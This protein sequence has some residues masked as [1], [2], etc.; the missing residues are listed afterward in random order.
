MKLIPEEISYLRKEARR[1]KERQDAYYEYMKTREIKTSQGP[2]LQ[3][4]GDTFT[5]DTFQREIQNYHS[6][7]DTL[8]NAEY[9]THPSTEKIEV[10]TKFVVS[11]ES[12]ED[13]DLLVLTESGF[14]FLPNDMF[15]TIDSPL[16]QEIQ[17]KKAGES[18]EFSLKDDIRM[19]L[20]RRS[21]KGEIKE[22]KTDRKLYVQFIRN[23][24]KSHRISKAIPTTNEE[25]LNTDDQRKLEITESQK[26]LLEIELKRLTKKTR[27]AGESCRLTNIKKILRN[28]TIATPRTDDKIGIGSTFE[29]V[30]TNG[31]ET[32]TKECEMIN[33]AVGDELEGEY[34]EKISPLGINIY[35]LEANDI[36]HFRQGNQ[37]YKGV[38][39]NVH[40]PRKTIEH[41]VH[42][43][44]K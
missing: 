24:Q 16:G 42:Q 21:I 14:G 27:N 31:Y 3:A 1:L 22:I 23:K 5:E 30:I 18:F 34:V 7:M 28:A 17:G 41:P 39:S 15:V 6:I 38:V 26:E 10:G 44:K 19:S 8:E 9:I 4:V 36:F 35:G 32:L 43:Y 25:S 37:H 2:E 13:E 11:Y 33:I 20:P 40:N 29:I 12:S